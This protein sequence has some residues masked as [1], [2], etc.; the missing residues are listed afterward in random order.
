MT[1]E[2]LG[3]DGM[4]I[5]AMTAE[6]L[7]IYGMSVIAMISEF[8][9]I[10]SNNV[11]YRH[12]CRVHRDRWHASYS[13][14]CRVPREDGMPVIAMIAEFCEPFLIGPEHVSM[15]SS[16]CWK[17]SSSR[18]RCALNLNWCFFLL[19]SGCV[20]GPWA[21]TGML[22]MFPVQDMGA[23]FWLVELFCDGGEETK[24]RVDQLGFASNGLLNPSSFTLYIGLW[25]VYDTVLIKNLQVSAK[26][27]V[28]CIARFKRDLCSWRPKLRDWKMMTEFVLDLA[29][30]TT[31]HAALGVHSWGQP[32]DER[33]TAVQ[34]LELT[35]VLT[36]FI[37]TLSDESINRGLVCAHKHSITRT[38]KILTFMS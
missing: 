32:A 15:S 13:H 36:P 3:L 26:P 9:W 31:G 28:C 29:S 17:Y 25:D 33:D 2:F 37:K 19:A 22:E 10:D 34:R 7:E 35:W 14:D 27:F 8:S 24:K 12:G 11:S 38:Q 5:T 1:A 4:S 30:C 6:F 20:Q 23:S 18:F 21:R 16:V